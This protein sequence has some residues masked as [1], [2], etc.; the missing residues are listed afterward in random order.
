MTLINGGNITDNHNNHHFSRLIVEVFFFILRSKRLRFTREKSAWK[1]CIERLCVFVV[2]FYSFQSYSL[3]LG[4]F[5][6]FPFLAFMLVFFPFLFSDA[7][8]FIFIYLLFIIYCFFLRGGQFWKGEIFCCGPSF[9][10]S[11]SLLSRLPPRILLPTSANAE[12][13]LPFSLLDYRL[14]FR[15]FCAS[16]PRTCTW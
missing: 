14:R 16:I 4:H 3:T 5:N 13:P 8:L 10:E 12:A 9:G 15:R 7:V 6:V 1:Q 2:C 11:L